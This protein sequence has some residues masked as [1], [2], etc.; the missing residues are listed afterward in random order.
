MCVCEGFVMCGCIG[1]MYTVFWQVF[2]NLT[3]VFLILTEVFPCFFLSCKANARLKLTKT[4]HGPHSS[5][6]VI[7]VVRLLFVL[8][9]VLFVC[10]FVLPPGDNPIAVNL[11][12]LL[13][14]QPTVGFSLIQWFS[15]IVPFLT[16]LSPPSY[17]HYLQIFFKIAVNK[18]IKC[19]LYHVARCKKHKVNCMFRPKRA[20]TR[21]CIQ[22]Y[23][24]HISGRKYHHHAFF[25]K[26]T[27]W[28]KSLCAPDHCIVIF[29]CT[30]TFWSPC[31]FYKKAWWWYF[32]PEICTKYICIQRLVMALFGRNTQLTLCFLHRATWYN[33][34]LIYLLTAILYQS[35]WW[36]CVPKHVV[37]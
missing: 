33:W 1:Y 16:L 37:C 21:R 36:L 29:R 6:L 18:Y 19:Q 17:S 5:T 28:S 15:S 31:I 14:L 8:F 27:G 25:I 4:G 23:L 24:V 11:L 35:W 34:Y 10:K 26:H 32:R 22:I 9:Y 2:L 20:I 30:E 3:N 12:L 7:C 13:A